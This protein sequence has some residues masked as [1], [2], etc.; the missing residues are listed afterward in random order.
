MLGTDILKKA[1]S[2]LGET[3]I[4]GANVPLDNADWTGPW[5]CAE[6]V[7]W[8]VYQTY[9]LVFGCGTQNLDDA[10][11]YTGHWAAE[12]VNR[13]IVI[14]VEQ[15]SRTPGAFL[16]RKPRSN[17]TRI[18][19]VGVAAGDGTI[20]EAAGANLGV[21]I[22]PIEGRRWDLGMLLP[23][24]N[25]TSSSQVDQPG[26]MSSTLILRRQ[27]PP[28]FDER[29][30]DVQEALKANGIDPGRAD[31]LFGPST[32]R[33][34]SSFQLAKGLIVDGEVGPSTGRALGLTHWGIS[35]PT[36]RSPGNPPVA[37]MAIG[38]DAFGAVVNK[39]KDFAT[40]RPEYDQLF[41]TCQVRD[42]NQEISSLAGRIAAARD[43]YVGF[44]ASYAG[45]TAQNMPWYF[46]ALVHAMEASGDVGRFRTHLHNGDPLTAP[47][48]H[49]PAGRPNPSGSNFTW[50]ESAKDALAIAK[51]DQ[52]TDWSLARMLYN[53]EKY[54]GFG[55]RGKGHATAYL[56]SYSNHYIKGKYVADG[57]WSDSA[58]SRQPGVAAILKVLV[59]NGTVA[60]I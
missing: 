8:L 22:G 58:V 3:Y 39:A 14:P 55:P 12:A 17:P 21:R 40:N 16:I 32:E 15:A 33:A 44:V 10:E 23:G 43:R 47:T 20:F 37:P 56:W 1:R 45:Q 9:G 26:P 53:F 48:T 4:F 31:G 11:P 54:N 30:V 2:H 38:T 46:V 13:G 57:V 42:M 36:P 5:D 28:I 27:T 50:E 19:H 6:Y 29:V 59:D 60:V 41:E 7:S 34:V 52:E 35:D 51:L 18:G 24:V 49:V 25:Y